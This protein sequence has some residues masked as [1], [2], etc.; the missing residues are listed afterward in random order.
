MRAHDASRSKLGI[1]FGWWSVFLAVA[2]L[3]CGG[4][5]GLTS[6]SPQNSGSS[7]PS[8]SIT[9]PAA[10]A[11]VTGDIKVSTSASSDT[12]SVQ[13][14][15]DGAAAGAAVNASPFTLSLNTAT[16]SNGS[17]ALT[18]V[19]GNSAKQTATSAAVSIT[20]KNTTS[21]PPTISI[22]SPAS[23]ATVSGTITI[24]TNVSS[25]TT[26]VQ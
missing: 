3:S 12:S 18:V 13:L 5:V 4:C 10:G 15:V 21:T 8:I 24:A 16:L 6:A 26:S 20:V 19:A 1:P 11:T 2:L 17:H 7:A 23:G 14:L 25:N 9:S 22:T